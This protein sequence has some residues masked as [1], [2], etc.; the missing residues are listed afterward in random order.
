MQG[1]E[2]AIFNGRWFGLFLGFSKQMQ[3]NKMEKNSN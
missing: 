3:K 1:E 2:G